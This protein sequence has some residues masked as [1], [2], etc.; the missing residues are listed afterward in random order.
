MRSNLTVLEVADFGGGPMAMAVARIVCLFLAVGQGL[1]VITTNAALSGGGAFETNPV[2]A[3]A[4]W[5][6]GPYWWLTKAALGG[7]MVYFALTL[8]HLTVRSI[9]LL[10]FAAKMTV[11]VVLCNYF[12]WL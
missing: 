3:V 9:A 11:L 1:D 7:V 6:L 10:G 2:M 8:R 5:A 12:G 4:M